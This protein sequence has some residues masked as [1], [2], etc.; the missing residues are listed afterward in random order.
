MPVFK[1][2]P[3]GFS[4]YGNTRGVT[5]CGV[6]PGVDSL[7]PTI[8][9]LYGHVKTAKQRTIKQQ[10]G[11]WYTGCWLAG[12]YIWYSEERPA[13]SVPTSYYSMWHYN[14]LCL[15][16]MCAMVY[17]LVGWYVC[18]MLYSHINYCYIMGDQRMM[19]FGFSGSPP[20]FLANKIWW[21]W[22][23]LNG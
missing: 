9:T 2:I 10:Y 23:P 3:A 12:C 16:V 22:C 8:L 15:C 1:K 14:Y 21:W 6:C 17:L 5:I 11:D 19:S 7:I 20:P 4:S 18:C 13:A